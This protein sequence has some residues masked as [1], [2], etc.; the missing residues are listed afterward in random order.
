MGS[1]SI[2]YASCLMAALLAVA[3]GGDDD[4][5]MANSAGSAGKGNAGSGAGG[6]GNSGGAGKG[7]AGSG[8]S[9]GGESGG[10]DN[11][12]G[13]SDAGGAAGT[14]E[15][16]AG[17]PGQTGSC[18]HLTELVHAMIKEDTTGKSSPRPVNGVVFCDDPADPGAYDDLF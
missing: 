18:T 12:G 17:T 4:S 15:G 5:T 7:N 10:T 6:K 14:P 3:C 16:A 1:R 11:A 2:L 9:P 8:A 13:T